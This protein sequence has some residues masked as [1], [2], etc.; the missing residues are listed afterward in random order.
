MQTRSRH[1]DLDFL[2]SIQSLDSRSRKPV[3][4]RLDL[5]SRF[6]H[7]EIERKRLASKLW[8]W[9]SD[10]FLCFFFFHLDLLVCNIRNAHHEL[11]DLDLTNL[12]LPQFED[13]LRP[14]S[15]E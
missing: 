11:L 5:E 2:S 8:I 13:R 7:I 14:I 6:I 10:L 9:I 4:R 15:G 12:N 3:H 1:L